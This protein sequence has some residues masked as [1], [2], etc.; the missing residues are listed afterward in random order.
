[1]AASAALLHSVETHSSDLDQGERGHRAEAEDKDQG[2]YFRGTDVESYYIV[3]TEP[4][5]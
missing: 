4:V 2:I 1:M 3:Y 5:G